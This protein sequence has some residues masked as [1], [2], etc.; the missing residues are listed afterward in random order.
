[1][2]SRTAILSLF[3]SL[4]VVS[5]YSFSAGARLAYVDIKAAILK[6]QIKK[7]AD[8][9]LT[10]EFGKTEQKIIKDKK[11]LKELAEKLKKTGAGKVDDTTFKLQAEYVKL[12]RKL[13]AESFSFTKNVRAKQIKEQKKIKSKVMKAIAQVAKKENFDVVLA[14]KVVIY[15][16]EQADITKKVTALMDKK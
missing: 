3:L 16:S 12:K 5:S 8:K 7:D 11:K 15:N 4:L 10:I 14:K 2:Q 9:R 6:S 1:M 13:K